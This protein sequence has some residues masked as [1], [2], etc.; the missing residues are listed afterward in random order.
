MK[1]YRGLSFETQLKIEFLPL[2]KEIIQI[3]DALVFG[4]AKNESNWG[5]GGAVSSPIRSR[6]IPGQCPGKGVGANLQT[7]LVFFI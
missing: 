6:A 3:M 4:R 7:I 5:S 1:K 2:N